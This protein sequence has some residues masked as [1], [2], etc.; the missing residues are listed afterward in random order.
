MGI[1][2]LI[3]AIE[4]KDEE[5]RGLLDADKLD[6]AE[7]VIT[8]KRKLKKTL[9]L[10]R[11]LEADEMKNLK[12]Q[13]NNKDNETREFSKELQARSLLKKVGKL[14]LTEEERSA[15][16][17]T[18]GE[19]AIIPEEFITQKQNIQD[20]YKNLEPY[21]QII[22]VTSTQ[23]SVPIQDL[24]GFL[25][26]LDVDKKA[27]STTPALTI[28][29]YKIKSKGAITGISNDTI[30]SSPLSVINDVIIPD[31]EIKARNTKNKEI[32]ASVS[33]NSS[34]VAITTGDKVEDKLA[35][36]ISGTVPSYRG[37]LVIIT[38]SV[39]YSYIDNLK[40]ATGRRDDRVTEK[41]GTLYFKNKE[42]IDLNDSSLPTLTSG[43]TMVFYVVNLKTIPFCKKKEVKIEEAGKEYK[44]D[45]D[46]TYYR[47]ITKF[48]VAAVDKG[49]VKGKKLEA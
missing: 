40:D 22:P 9:K 45:E 6:E 24:D 19:G 33:S 1:E 2:E 20:G 48:G 32:M 11:Q 38:N 17:A 8:E 42:V 28:V 37:G 41:D 25:E 4:E 7:A 13:E 12:G 21:C 47:V 39:G 34:A 31:Y 30:E 46:K 43:K 10:K 14:K 35:T 26:D 3:K 44:F 29:D 16:T 5:A 27:K 15:A 49:R 36:S 18:S 23:G